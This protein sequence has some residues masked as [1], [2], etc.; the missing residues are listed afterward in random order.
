MKIKATYLLSIFL[1]IMAL[2]MGWLYRSNSQKLENAR[3]EN[4]KMSRKIATSELKQKDAIIQKRISEQLEEIAQQQKLITENQRAIALE[5]S[6]IAEQKKQEAIVQKQVADKAKTRAENA[7]QDAENQRKIAVNQKEVAERAEKNANRLRMLALGQSLS[8]KSINQSNTGNDSLATMLALAAWQ[9]TNNNNGDLYQTELF[10]AL[11]LASNGKNNFRA[12]SRPIRDVVVAPGSSTDEMTLVSVD[13]GGTV[14]SWKGNYQNL[15]HAILWE[16]KDYD[17]RKAV[18]NGSG[19]TLVISDAK[20]N[21]LVFN[22]PFSSEPLI[23]KCSDSKVM[24]LAFLNDHLLAYTDG[25]NVIQ[26][27]LNTEGSSVMQLYGHTELISCLAYDVESDRML[28]G[29]V[30]G[31]AF[32]YYSKQKAETGKILSMNHAVS[33]ISISTGKLAFGTASGNIYLYDLKASAYHELVGHIS[34]VNDLIF[35]D[36]QLFSIAYDK[37]IRLWDLKGSNIES[38][39][40]EE[41]NNWGYALGSVPGSKQV[42]SSGADKQLSIYTV[43]PKELAMLV[44]ARVKRDFTR[45]E[46]NT[47]VDPTVPYKSLIKQ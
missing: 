1:L 28:I 11:K 15:Y 43:D 41:Q 36:D 32:L 19:N 9:F 29:D 6:A 35:N 46:W 45:E 16:N 14:I 37:T 23:I 38:I 22:K 8:A 33:A 42:V 31:N 20:G 7:F 26:T 24:G 10:Q 2:A 34:Q 25:S 5:Q 17:L 18:F 39:V 4:V 3:N 30:K 13:E 27:D 21:I 47:Y 44:K 40:I 12:H